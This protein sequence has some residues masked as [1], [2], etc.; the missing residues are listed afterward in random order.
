LIIDLIL[1][2]AAVDNCTL[3]FKILSSKSLDIGK[4]SYYL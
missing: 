3:K 2:L 4:I 1:K